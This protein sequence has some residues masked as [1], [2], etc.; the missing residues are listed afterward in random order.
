MY[1]SDTEMPVVNIEQAHAVTDHLSIPP[2]H[3]K[4]EKSTSEYINDDHNHP[5]LEIPEISALPKALPD[6]MPQE[7]LP[8]SFAM[9]VFTKNEHAAYVPDPE[10]KKE[11]FYRKFFHPYAIIAFVILIFLA[12]TILFSQIAG[13]RSGSERTIPSQAVLLPP[14]KDTALPASSTT[15]ARS[16]ETGTVLGATGA[17]GSAGP[18]EIGRASCRERV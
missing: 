18:T 3:V 7:S 8:T 10:V 4:S 9:P 5:S 6:D 17:T 13:I 12:S 16:A 15:T 2:I 14:S 11:P 1:D